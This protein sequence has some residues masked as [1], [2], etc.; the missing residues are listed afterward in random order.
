MRERLFAPLAAVAMGACLMLPA[1]PATGQPA[2][3]RL[4]AADRLD[5]QDAIA[6]MLLAIDQCDWARVRAAFADEVLVD[7]TALSGGS[8]SRVR[9]DALMASWQ[10]LVPGFEATQHLVGPVVAQ[11]RDTEVVAHTAVRG[12][13]HIAGA[14][15]PVWMVA[16][17]YTFA[18]TRRG[19][20]WRIS[21][22]RLHVAYQEG[23]LGLPALAQQRVREG[24]G[25]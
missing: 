10:A 7:Y 6:N 13:H 24:K 22:I 1:T 8:P 17:R 21:A 20:H 2:G 15:P 3:Q 11:R 4:S 5:I 16:G 9:A 25:R 23:N 14:A 18:L 12:Y 19:A